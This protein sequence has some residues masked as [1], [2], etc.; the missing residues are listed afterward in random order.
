MAGLRITR[1]L[2]I[3]ALVAGLLWSGLHWLLWSVAGA[4]G[5][6]VLRLAAFMN[7]DPLRVTWLAETLD[8]VGTVAQWLV[9]LIWLIGMIVLALVTSLGMRATSNAEAMIR[10]ARMAAG[11]PSAG[12]SPAVEGVVEA[13]HVE[14]GP[15]PAP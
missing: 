2:A 11:D 13:R 1:P 12:H 6:A 9:A 15:P 7:V 10:E 4:G 3:I 5:N 14:P 8:A